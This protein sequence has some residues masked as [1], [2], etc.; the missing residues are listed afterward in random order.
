MNTEKVTHYHRDGKRVPF[1]WFTIRPDSRLGFVV[2]G[3][4]TYSHNSVLSGQTMK[5]YLACFDTDIEALEI[6][7]EAENGNC[8]TDPQVSLSHLPDENDFVAGGAYPD[9]YEDGY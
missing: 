1:D 7:P 4:G 6:Y 2:H 9:D 8:W 5:K 3:F